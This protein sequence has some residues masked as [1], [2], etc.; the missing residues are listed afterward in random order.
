M[1]ILRYSIAVALGYLSGSLPVGY[2]VVRIF[3]GVDVRNCESGRTGGA[4]VWRAAG[5]VPAILTVLG[6]LLKGM[7]A[8]LIARY[9]LGTPLAEILAGLAAVI[10]HNHSAF[11]GWRGGAGTITNLGVISVL[12]FPVALALASIGFLTIVISRI[13][14]VASLTMACLSPLAFLG[15]AL[16]AH[17][18]LEYVAYGILAGAEIVWALRPN[19]T[20]L[21]AGTE[22]RLGWGKNRLINQ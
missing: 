20:R 9:F 7:A 17:R 22:R 5:L 2:L 11:L 3:K 18:P 14:S 1:D 13:A 4:N 21:R 12:S 16:F 19:I 10:G 15:L 8:V 6:D